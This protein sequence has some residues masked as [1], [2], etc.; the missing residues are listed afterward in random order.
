MADFSSQRPT[1]EELL[2]LMPQQMRDD[3]AAASRA[4][5]KQAGTAAGV[6][7]VGLNTDALDFA[8]AV[9]AHWGKS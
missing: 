9:L 7:R 4:L 1:D 8:R 2:A 6:F 5:A 3:L